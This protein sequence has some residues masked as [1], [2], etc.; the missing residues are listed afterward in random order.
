MAFWFLH[1]FDRPIELARDEVR[2]LPQISKQY[3]L[4]VANLTFEFLRGQPNPNA[5]D[6][7]SP[8]LLKSARRR[9]RIVFTSLQAPVMN[10]GNMS[11]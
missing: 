5:D 9:N 2:G 6:V 10:K 11:L 7:A 8:H 3:Y 1:P 4:A